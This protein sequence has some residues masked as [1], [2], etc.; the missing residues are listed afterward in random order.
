MKRS[1]NALHRAL[2]ETGLLVTEL[3]G[4][5]SNTVQLCIR[6]LKGES[7]SLGQERLF[8]DVNILL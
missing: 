3:G 6:C 8:R 2:T 5:S 4:A 1:S 7:L